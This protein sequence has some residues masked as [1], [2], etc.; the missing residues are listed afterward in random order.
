MMARSRKALLIAL[1]GAALVFIVGV[2]VFK[3]GHGVSWLDAA[4]FVITTMTTVGY[5]DISLLVMT[6]GL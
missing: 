3:L 2:V 5:G 6:P 4:Y 1:G